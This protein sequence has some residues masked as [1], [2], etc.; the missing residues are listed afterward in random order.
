M[1]TANLFREG[2]AENS[3]RAV[4]FRLLAAA[5]GRRGQPQAIKPFHAAAAAAPSPIFV[6]YGESLMKDA[7]ASCQT[8]SAGQGLVVRTCVQHPLKPDTETSTAGVARACVYGV[9]SHHYRLCRV[10]QGA[11]MREN[12]PA[13]HGQAR[14]SPSP[15]R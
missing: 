11:G 1:E 5:A 10:G 14:R 12:D 3:K 7:T 6:L 13:A 4:G 15:S 8:W 9:I 2:G